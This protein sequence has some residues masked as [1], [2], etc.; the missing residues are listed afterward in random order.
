VRD[1]AAD[2][3]ADNALAQESQPCSYAGWLFLVPPVCFASALKRDS[4]SAGR[5]LEPDEF[6]R[7]A[8]MVETGSGKR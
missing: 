1:I 6:D 8:S 5:K 2:G 4:F 7:E 3:F